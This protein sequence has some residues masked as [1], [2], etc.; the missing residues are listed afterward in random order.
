MTGQNDAG[1]ED[2]ERGQGQG[3]QGRY[4]ENPAR[5]SE[6]TEIP[7]EN[8]VNDSNVELVDPGYHE[9]YLRGQ[10][11]RRAFFSDLER[12][13]REYSGRL[14]IHYGLR[15]HIPT[16]GVDRGHDVNIERSYTKL[17]K[18]EL[19]IGMADPFALRNLLRDPATTREEAF[20]KLIKMLGLRI[21]TDDILRIVAKNNLGIGAAEDISLD[22]VLAMEERLKEKLGDNKFGGIED[23]YKEAIKGLLPKYDRQK[24]ADIVRDTVVLAAIDF[25]ENGRLKRGFYEYTT[26]GDNFFYAGEF[27]ERGKLIQDGH[28]KKE[29]PVRTMLKG[30][31]RRYEAPYLF[32][33]YFTSNGRGKGI[34]P[35]ARLYRWV[36][37]EKIVGLFDKDRISYPELVISLK[38]IN[39][40]AENTGDKYP[41]VLM[42]DPFESAA[43]AH[44]VNEHAYKGEEKIHAHLV[45]GLSRDPDENRM[46]QGF[47]EKG[48]LK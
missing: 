29:N 38:V 37:T 7:M 4:F 5:R 42:P 43:T 8:I 45:P 36:R 33:S 47:D 27:A 18:G 40:F 14:G 44:F 32:Y 35:F 48:F 10:R 9:R 16:I 22:A 24:V 2:T 25:V 39:E 17:R 41:I 30:F 46:S 3:S 13:L 21:P 31:W 20:W 12:L 15:D 19:V 11:T 34:K 23:A 1:T 26:G 6:I 28:W